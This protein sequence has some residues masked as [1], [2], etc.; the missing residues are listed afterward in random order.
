VQ[1]S[2]ELLPLEHGIDTMAYFGTSSRIKGL[3]TAP[4]GPIL[5]MPIV[6]PGLSQWGLPRPV[7]GD[8]MFYY[9]SELEMGVTAADM[10]T[11][12][13]E[14]YESPDGIDANP[15]IVDRYKAQYD[16]MKATLAGKFADFQWD[17]TTISREAKGRVAPNFRRELE[18]FYVNKGYRY[19]KA[20]PDEAGEYAV[21]YKPTVEELMN[22][23]NYGPNGT[24]GVAQYGTR[25]WKFA[26]R[27][28]DTLHQRATEEPGL[29]SEDP[30][31]PGYTI[32][33]ETGEFTYNRGADLLPKNLTQ[34]I[35]YAGV[36]YALY[37]LYTTTVDKRVTGSK[38]A[39]MSVFG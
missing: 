22:R 10:N 34:G 33:N 3:G 20:G 29:F 39:A 32:L 15:G 35:L 18:L 12:T 6:N 37:K 1:H 25:A 27:D 16:Q 26:Q 9:N 13:G 28:L 4:G 36:G 23:G 2:L 14:P 19:S 38:S 21:P 7:V 8:D 17:D 24:A 31:G 30:P 11:N 5:D